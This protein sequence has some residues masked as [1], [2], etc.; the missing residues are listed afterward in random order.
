MPNFSTVFLIV[1]IAIPLS[2]LAL[3]YQCTPG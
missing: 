2:L 1:F 3:A